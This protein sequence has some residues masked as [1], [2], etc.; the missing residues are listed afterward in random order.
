MNKFLSG[1]V[2]ECEDNNIKYRIFSLLNKDKNESDLDYI[3]RFTKEHNFDGLL[4]NCRLADETLIALHKAGIKIVLFKAFLPGYNIPYV[5]V[6]HDTA[7][8]MYKHF[9]KL[10]YKRIAYITGPWDERI[11]NESIFLIKQ[12]CSYNKT[13]FDFQ[14]VLE[15]S[16]QRDRIP[17]MISHLI[18]NKADAI[19]VDDDIL[20]LAAI[21]ECKKR[22]LRV[23]EDIAIAGINDLVVNSSFSPQLTSVYQPVADAGAKSSEMLIRLIK[24]QGVKDS[25]VEFTGKLDIRESCGAKLKKE[26]K[27]IVELE[28]V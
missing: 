28:T 14:R 15:G 8:L 25:A 9:L 2:R 1:A 19:I 27:D 24:G 12:L 4:I 3:V 23:P 20:A 16:Y 10:G 5:L 26:L 13:K 21:A 22:G 11:I 6:G 18:K 7:C 17:Y